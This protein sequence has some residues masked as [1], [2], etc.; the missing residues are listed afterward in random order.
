MLLTL[1]C[2]AAVVR[3]AP[4]S[5]NLPDY[6]QTKPELFPGPTPTGDPAFLAQTNPA[7]FPSTT[8]IPPQP[9]ETQIP[10]RGN[11]KNG[12]IFQLMAQLSHYFPNPD[13]FGVDEYK[14]PEE[15]KI[16]QLNML[17]R[18]GSRY[19]TSDSGAL[20]LAEKIGNHT[21]KFTGELEFLNSWKSK[22]GADILVPVGKEELFESGTL[23][24]YL[25]GQLYPNDGSKI[26]VRSTT[27]DRMT[28]SA[29]Y[30]LAGF[31][32]LDWTQNAT[33]VL[34]IETF[35]GASWNNTLSGSVGCNNSYSFRANAGNNA[36]A[37]W[38]KIYL[39]DAVTR[40][41][42]LSPGFN[43]TTSQAYNAQQ[44]CAY[45]TVALGFSSFCDLFTFSEW[46]GFEYS[47]DLSFAGN[48]AFQSPTGRAV[49]IGYVAEILAR[50]QHHVIKAP[51][52]QINTTLSG[53][54]TT[55]PTNQTLYFD[56]SHDTDIMSILTAFGLRQFAH[57]M[58]Q[59]RID[60]KRS[61]IVSHLTPFAA[62]LDM[63]IIH[64]PR[65]LSG[66]RKGGDKYEYG[67][68][69][70]YIHF[71]LNQRTLPLGVSLPECGMR[72]DGWCELNTFM[73]VQTENLKRA[74]FEE[75]CFGH[76]EPSPFGTIT[77]GV[78]LE[79]K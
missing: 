46:E 77:D 38:N 78:P 25:Y 1:V 14:L 72:D 9:L 28:K 48:D 32:G 57:V 55:F 73:K 12:N 2:L 71:V 13:G 26:I 65:P 75:S 67:G 33:L 74:K 45:E 42:K 27:Q 29:E 76:Y 11:D 49:G 50:L 64:T 70:K 4:V 6:F 19:P 66:Q 3:A 22:L 41:N 37:A 35:D 7:P 20:V 30:F 56:F 43:W 63:E 52:A 58:S 10:I 18:H 68:E 62:R 24:Q 79:K 21:S 69:T 47:A 16:V 44:L 5:S 39:A 61:L 54:E 17:S 34:G 53:S 15:A 36:S 23:H 40:L 8:Y 51:F 60:K 31:F 59:D